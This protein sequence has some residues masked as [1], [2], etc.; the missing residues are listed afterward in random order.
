MGKYQDYS[1]HI[2]MLFSQCA[3]GQHFVVFIA[4]FVV[5]GY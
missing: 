5:A 4:V 3:N 1:T 2:D